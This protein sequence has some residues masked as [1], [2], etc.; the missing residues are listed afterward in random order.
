M[1]RDLLPGHDLVDVLGVA[2]DDVDQD[3]D[4]GLL[5]VVVVRHVVDVAE[6]IEVAVPATDLDAKDGHRGR[7]VA[8]ASLR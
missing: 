6:R 3:P 5:Q 7:L 4:P 1:E 8:G 2:A